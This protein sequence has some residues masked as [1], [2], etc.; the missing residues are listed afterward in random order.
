VNEPLNGVEVGPYAGSAAEWDD[1]VRGSSGW[2]HF[3]QYGWRDVIGRVMG[4]ETPYLGARDA[5]G[6]LVGVLP[7]ARVRS[8]VFGD[9]LVSLPFLNYGGPLGSAVAVRQLA[10]AAVELAD[11]RGCKLLELRSRR[12]LP[13]SL[14]A[15]HR[16]VTVT[17]RL[18]PEDPDA[19]LSGFKSK[20]RSQVRR[21]L[22]EGVEV[23]FGADQLDGF[24]QVFAEHMRDLGTPVLGRDWFGEIAGTFGDSVWF[25]CARIDGKPV[26]GGCG[27]RWEKEFEMTWASSLWAYSRIA[28]NMLLYWR[29]MERAAEEG[30]ETF[31][32][33]RCTPDGGTHRFKMQWGG[34]D[35]ELWWYHRPSDSETRTP[36]PEEGAYAWGP[37]LW[38]HLP[39]PVAGWLGPRIVRFIP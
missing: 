4:H 29:F 26:A 39:L 13:L 23:D 22:K 6:E 31:N 33:G 37:R 16:K 17:L 2:T 36:S 34:D 20:V 7:L 8:L 21:P 12:E 18:S 35:E 9:Y 27:F 10:S 28:P 30:L 15:S 5:A 14:P 11:A 24:Y 38:R 1:V 32:F 3:H 19:V 25:G